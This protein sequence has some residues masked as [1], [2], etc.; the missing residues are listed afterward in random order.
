MK[1]V[2]IVICMIVGFGLMLLT[3]VSVLAQ[4]EDKGYRVFLPNGPGPHPAVVFLSGCSGLKPSF[5]PNAY[6]QSAE[7]LRTEGFIVV[8]ADY[9]SQRNLS[10]CFGGVTPEEAAQDAIVAA[11]WLRSQQDVDKRLISLM[12]WSWGGGAALLA[13]GSYSE[14]EL[15]FT[16]AIVYYPY[17]T[18]KKPWTHRLPVLVL[19]GDADNL[20]P[21]EM[22]KSVLDISAQKG[23]IKVITY[24][25]AKHCFDMS[26]DFRFH[27]K[28][29]AA[30]WEE[31]QKFLNSTK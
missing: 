22:C 11:S 3:V 6:E 25:G 30:A 7:L 16:R 28:A 13:L 10:S 26:E 12:G 17:C 8:W 24:S 20:A 15:I 27:P 18:S 29:A 19:Q 4:I 5:A 9:L 31:V 23:D 2:N 1:D 21:P 14:E